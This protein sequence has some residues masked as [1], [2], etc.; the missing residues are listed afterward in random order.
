[1]Q[2]SMREHVPSLRQVRPPHHRHGRSVTGS[3]GASETEEAVP[4]LWPAA[5][6]QEHGQENTGNSSVWTLAAAARAVGA[7][8]TLGAYL[9]NFNSTSCILQNL[10]FQY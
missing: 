2:I 8:K 9:C 10:C 6:A 3:R 5:I 7:T 1:M 4:K